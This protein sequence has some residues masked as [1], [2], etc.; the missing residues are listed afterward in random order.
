MA[1]MYGSA[2]PV[3]FRAVS[4]RNKAGKSDVG[5]LRRVF[6]AVRRSRA[7]RANQ[8]IAHHLLQSGGRL[9]DEIERE[10]MRQLTRNWN[11]RP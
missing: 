11:L 6:E 1:L 8:E 2:D 3:A 7:R 4:R 5:F 9:T 10:M